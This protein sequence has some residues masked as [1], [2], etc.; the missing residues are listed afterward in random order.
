M[1]A[2]ARARMALL[3]ALLSP[4]VARADEPPLPAWISRLPEGMKVYNTTYSA[5]D[6][7]A[8]P[9]RV[10]AGGAREVE[11]G[12]R[13]DL[14][15]QTPGAIEAPAVFRALK[16]ALRACGFAEVKEIIAGGEMVLFRMKKGQAIWWVVGDVRGPERALL[17]V[18]EVA[19]L[20]VELTLAAPAAV[21]EAL[22]AEKGDF[23]FLAP[24]P[25][26]QYRGGRADPAPF[27]ARIGGGPEELVA[28]GSLVKSYLQPG[29]VS[30]ALFLAVYG[31][32]LTRAGWE[33]TE[34]FKGADAQITAHYSRDGRNLWARLHDNGDGYSLAV[35]DAARDLH[36]TL[37]RDC[38][39]ALYGVL[40]DFDKAT[41]Q[42]VSEPILRQVAAL[43]AP[44][45]DAKLEVQGHTDNVGGDEYNQKLSEARA[46]SVVEWLTSHGVEAGRLTSRGYGR[47]QPIADNATVE[48]RAKNR[49]VEI[50]DPACSAKK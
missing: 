46:R 44:G 18:L 10:R 36:A 47:T 31:D 13:W 30:V 17:Q 26:A 6:E 50:A 3:V 38:H 40:F 24:L 37:A 39:V 28:Q 15:L 8:I 33:I 1:P 5:W 19:P 4:A 32:A 27:Y 48:G 11:R 12:R 34:Q 42:P 35:A 25:G 41:L 23:P 45:S 14:P 29:G 9:E 7:L 20:P 43:V 16:A 2:N 22:D 49:R 21:P